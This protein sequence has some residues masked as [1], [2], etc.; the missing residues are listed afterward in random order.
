MKSSVLLFFKLTS[1]GEQ[2][3]DKKDPYAS[4]DDDEYVKWYNENF[5]NGNGTD[6]DQYAQANKLFKKNIET[7]GLVQEIKNN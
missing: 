4:D 5:C 2:K 3:G 7:E 6:D 1:E